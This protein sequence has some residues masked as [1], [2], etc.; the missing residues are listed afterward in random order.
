ML[1]Q[2]KLV[3][4]DWDGTLMDSTGRIVSSMQKAAQAINLPVP[5]EHSVKQ[6][7]GLN[8]KLAFKTLFPFASEEQLQQLFLAYRE[9]YVT[10]DM[11]PSPLYPGAEACLQYLKSR[12]IKI[13]I[14]TGKARFGL[15]RVLNEV[16][17]IRQYLDD[18]ICDDESESKPSADMLLQLSQRQQLRTNE[19]LMVGDTEFDLK[20][21]Q[22]AGVKSIGVSHGAH[23][24]E[25]L[26]KYQPAK[27][28]H[29]LDEL[30]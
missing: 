8:L 3:V 16:N 17:H 9:L 30:R 21:A 10:K 25:Q 27:I 18:S 13:A 11:T 12:T 15:E 22:N 26:E 14:A 1:T 7:I 28:I 2:I 19:M 29:H 20:M 4:F 5:G 6:L 24:V 23:P